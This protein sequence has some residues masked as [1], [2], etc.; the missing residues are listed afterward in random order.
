MT[1]AITS[2]VLHIDNAITTVT[3]E[4]VTITPKPP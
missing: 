4:A 1:S 2:D 3:E